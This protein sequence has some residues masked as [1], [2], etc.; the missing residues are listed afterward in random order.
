MKLLSGLVAR[1]AFR[2]KV[3]SRVRRLVRDRGRDGFHE[4]VTRPEAGV[5]GRAGGDGGPNHY[6]LDAVVGGCPVHLSA[7][8]IPVYGHEV[9]ASVEVDGELV[10]MVTQGG[11]V[12][13]MDDP[14]SW[15]HVIDEMEKKP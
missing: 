6:V 10:Y 5:P 1:R 15:F 11:G 13:L 4:Q 9:I 12:E 2:R 14:V 3:A 7:N 8:M